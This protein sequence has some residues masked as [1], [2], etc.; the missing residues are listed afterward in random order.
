MRPA[1]R[2]RCSGQ[3]VRP[4]GRAGLD[5]SNPAVHAPIRA[6]FRLLCHFTYHAVT[7]GRDITDG[8]GIWP[9]LVGP[10]SAPAAAAEEILFAVFR[11][12]DPPH[13]TGSPWRLEEDEHP[14][15]VAKCD[16]L[17]I[18]NHQLV[19]APERDRRQMVSTIRRLGSTAL[20]S[21]LASAARSEC[22]S[23]P[24]FLD[25][26]FAALIFVVLRYEDSNPPAATSSRQA[27]TRTPPVLALLPL[28][29]SHHSQRRL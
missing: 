11:L 17:R 5:V 19:K 7:A 24:K 4:F 23:D 20:E 16:A 15:L 1:R 3:L 21:L 18:I 29:M 9:R 22:C 8:I 26:C 27:S 28:L 6:L 13:P 14:G 2:R 12:P 25:N 10:E